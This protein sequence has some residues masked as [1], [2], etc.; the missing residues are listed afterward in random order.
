M[1]E[2]YG[3]DPLPDQTSDDTDDGWGERTDEAGDDERIAREK[4]PHY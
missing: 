4:P 2:R 1:T 3:E